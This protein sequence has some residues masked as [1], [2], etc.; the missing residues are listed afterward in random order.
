MQTDFQIQA[1][2]RRCCVSGRELQVGEKFYSVLLEQAGKLVRQDYGAEAWKGPPDGAFSFWQGRVHPPETKR[3]PTFDDEMLLDCFVRL[4][5]QTEAS[6]VRFRYVLALLLM[7]RKQLE[8]RRGPT[9][10]PETGHGA[11]GAGPALSAHRRRVS[12]PQPT[13]DGTGNGVG[14]GRSVSGPRLGVTVDPP[15]L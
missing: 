9:G 3:R 14:S 5:G 8:V 6:K 10:G 4:E 11:G 13:P 7:R 2:S 15:V 12:G 1:S